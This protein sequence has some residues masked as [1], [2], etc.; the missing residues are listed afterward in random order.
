MN[1][2][3]DTVALA[4][5]C[6]KQYRILKERREEQ[7]RETYY[8]RLV[9]EKS[10]A[11]TENEFFM[12][13]QQFQEIGDYK[14]AVELAK[15]CD[16]QCRILKER[17]EEQERKTSYYELVQKK[18]Y[19]STENEFLMLAQQFRAMNGYRDTAVLANECDEQLRILETK[20][21]EQRVAEEAKRKREKHEPGWK[22]R[23]Q[24]R[25][26][27]EEQRTRRVQADKHERR[28]LEIRNY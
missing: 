25:V 7:E 22:E 5:E 24:K 23:E 12:L 11:S 21:C 17:R 6:D 27:R 28:I 9:Q 20:R 3:R 8:N 14:N 16:E 2:Y 26:E 18:D 4:S 10:K 19:A 13:A 15:E 1:G